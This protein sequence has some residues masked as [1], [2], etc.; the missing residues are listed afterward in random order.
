MVSVNKGNYGVGEEKRRMVRDTSRLDG[1]VRKQTVG[2][3]KKHGMR[4]G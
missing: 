3:W 2:K 4:E 1:V